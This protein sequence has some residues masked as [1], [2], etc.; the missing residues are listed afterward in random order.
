MVELLYIDQNAE[1]IMGKSHIEKGRQ[2]HCGICHAMKLPQNGGRM[3]APP[4][5]I[6]RIKTH[7]H[8]STAVDRSVVDVLHIEV[9]VNYVYIKIQPL[10]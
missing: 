6:G 2:F 8:E 3:Q 9:Y 5:V 4:K 7:C 10:L 1:L